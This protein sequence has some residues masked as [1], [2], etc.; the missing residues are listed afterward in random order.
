VHGRIQFKQQKGRA[1][2]NLFLII[3]KAP[4][5]A[6]MESKTCLQKL[7]QRNSTLHIA[8]SELKIATSLQGERYTAALLS[9]R[10]DD[11]HASSR[12]TKQTAAQKSM[13]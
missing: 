11:H 12:S 5:Q 9:P 8:T 1:G 3:R 2:T 4:K 6:K 10:Q 7:M 13:S